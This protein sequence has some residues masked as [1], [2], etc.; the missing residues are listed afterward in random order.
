MREFMIGLC[1]YI[2]GVFLVLPMSMAI[3]YKQP[4]ILC[5]YIPAFVLFVLA[6]LTGEREGKDED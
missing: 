2:F 3:A 5:A 1:G 4:W 6:V